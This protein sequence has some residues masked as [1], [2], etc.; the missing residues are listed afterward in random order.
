[1]KILVLAGLL[2]WGCAGRAHMTPQYG[3]AYRQTLER[4]TVHPDAG[5]R[6][7][8]PSGLDTQEAAII[9]QSYRSS[10]ARK[11]QPVP[12]EAAL[13]HVA[14]SSGSGKDGLP[15]ASVPPEPR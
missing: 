9:A 3:H 15:P 11:G 8:R 13:L 14:P 6:T 4:Q 5:E 12:Q 7:A 2:L 1:M 10:L